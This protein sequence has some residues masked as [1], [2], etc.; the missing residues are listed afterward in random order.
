MPWRNFRFSLG[1][2][3]LQDHPFFPDG[4]QITLGTYWRINDNTGF[5]TLH[6]F[7][8]EDSTLEVQQYQ[9]HRDLSSWTASLGGVILQ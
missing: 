7:E 8:I 1:N 9:I 3:Y 2:Y 5:S 4:N 6:R